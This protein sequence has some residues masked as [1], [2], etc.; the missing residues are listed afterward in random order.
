MPRFLFKAFQFMWFKNLT[1]YRLKKW[2]ETPESLAEKLTKR[3]LQSCGG[4]D[5]QTVGWV[6]PKSE[7]DPIIHQFGSQLLISL[8][9]EKKLLPAT[10]VNQFTKAR[11]TEIEEQQGYKPG[12]KELKEIKEN[13]VD[14]LLPR[15]FTIRSKIN[16]W[17]DPVDGW[18]IIDAANLSKADEMVTQLTKT[19]D[20]FAVS[21]IKTKL[22]PSSTMTSWLSANEAPASFT[23][24]QDCELRGRGESGSTVRYVKH[25]LELDEISKHLKAGK[26]VTRMA[27]TWNDKLSF[28]IH[29][30]L[31]LKKITPLDLIKE[32]AD[33]NGE[34]DSFD[35]DFAMMTGE[36]KKLIPSIVNELGGEI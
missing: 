20:G 13:M 31:Q 3:A 21:L 16:A 24:D 35:T 17:I 22:S 14:E 29:E 10:V 12:R 28:V 11:A 1:L 30:N 8:G 19:L 2:E 4:A 34:D 7:S 25:A 18:M 33:I 26:E 32:Q 27:M 23:I 5:M 15:A 9:I 36:L 6:S